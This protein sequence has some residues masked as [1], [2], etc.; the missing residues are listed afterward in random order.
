MKIAY[1]QASEL[2]N[3]NGKIKT[4]IEL[5]A[6]KYAPSGYRYWGRSFD[7]YEKFPTHIDTNYNPRPRP[8]AKLTMKQAEEIRNK[9]KPYKYSARKL[10]DEFSV[11]RGTIQ[12]ILKGKTY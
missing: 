5:R 11:S 7:K 1:I 3:R 4:L 10:A 2:T 12:Q 6:K 8:D 9:Y